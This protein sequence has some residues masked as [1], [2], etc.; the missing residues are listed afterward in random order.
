VPA[1]HGEAIARGR[2]DVLEALAVLADELT[3][4][5]KFG[6]DIITRYRPR[7]LSAEQDRREKILDLLAVTSSWS[8]WGALER[9][10]T[11]WRSEADAA[12]TQYWFSL[13]LTEINIRVGSGSNTL[14][15]AARETIDAREERVSAL[16]GITKF[17]DIKV[18]DFLGLSPADR[19]MAWQ[20][21]VGLAT[22][23]V[24]LQDGLAWDPELQTRWGPSRLLPWYASS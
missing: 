2:Q 21:L 17:A 10:T 22:Y 12:W 19:E 9:L 7:S 4:R 5:V 15:P 13:V 24:G 18:A 23:L 11:E 8:G 3:K 16:L 6:G 20:D 1:G 14:P